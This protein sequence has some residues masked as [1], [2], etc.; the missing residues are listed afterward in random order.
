MPSAALVIAGGVPAAPRR[1]VR[2]VLYW[3]P[4][5]LVGDLLAYSL[6][7]WHWP[8]LVIALGY[9][10][11]DL[12]L[13]ANLAL[14]G[15]AFLLSLA[16]YSLFENPLRH[17]RLLRPTR[18]ALVLWPS[19][20][21]AVVLVTAL[22]SGSLTQQQA[23]AAR[24]GAADNAANGLEQADLPTAFYRASVWGERDGEADG[25][26]GAERAGTAAA[27]AARRRRRHQGVLRGRFEPSDLPLGGRPGAAHCR[28]A[29]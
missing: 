19:T 9:V 15:G 2:V 26:A 16:T 24:L 18:S 11:H 22:A 29:G 3:G 4:M 6:Y 21:A 1:G 20:I 14:I 27:A 23:A 7:L 25:R 13:A 28:G 10:G 17:G 8:V 12:P 5:R